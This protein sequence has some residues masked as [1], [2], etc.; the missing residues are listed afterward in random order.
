MDKSDYWKERSERRI[1]NAEKTA[2][3]MLRDI[4]KLYVETNDRITKEIEAFYGR[5][6]TE[7]GLSIADVK[8]LLTDEELNKFRREALKYYED[9]SKH[10]YDPAYREQLKNKI[11]ISTTKEGRKLYSLRRNVSR[12]DY[13]QVQMR[14]AIENMYMQQNEKFT[15]NLSKTYEDTYMRSV[16]DTQ[17]SSGLFVPFNSL[18]KPLVEKAVQQKWLGE[19]YSDR[20]WADKDKLINTLEQTFTQ[21]I[22]L[23]KNPRAMASDIKKLTGVKYS[24]CERLARTEFNHIANQATE[25]SYKANGVEKYKFVATLDTRT[26]AICQELSG[27]VFLLSEAEEGVNYPPM[28]CYDDKTEVLTKQGWKL[29]KNCKDDDLYFTMNPETMFPEWQKA[30]KK[31]E[32]LY[33]GNLIELKNR[34]FDLRVTPNHKMILKYAKGN[35]SGKLRFV[36]ADKLPKWSNAIP[37]GINWVGENLKTA[38]LGNYDIPIE[39]YLKF[40]AWWLSD[41]SC[42]KHKNKNAYSGVIGQETYNNLMYETLKDL[43]F[44]IGHSEKCIRFSDYSVCNELSKFGKCNNKYIPEIIK[45]LSADLIEIFLKAYSIADGHERI[46]KSFKGGNFGTEITFF[47]TSNQLASDLGELILKVGGRP[48]FKLQKNKGKAV[49]HHNGL[50]I[51]NFDCW[52]ITWGKRQWSYVETLERNLI[53]YNDYVYCVELQ[54]YHTLYV[55]RNGKCTWSGNSNCRSTTIP[56]YDDVDYSKMEQLATDPKTGKTYYIP[57]D[58]SYTDWKN[59]LTEEQGKYYAANKKM[60][61]QYKQDVKQANEYRKLVTKAKKAGHADLFEGYN[62]DVKSFQRLK[63]LQPE[64]YEIIKNNAKIARGL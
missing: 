24:N 31:I 17:Q 4:K 20:I 18:N 12:L 26:S 52:H 21:D 55:R 29:F 53:S 37:R 56:Y 10:V 19:N 51:G 63:Y 41:G 61:A 49:Q 60:N 33:N 3:E 36:E 13:I 14:Y 38:R 22:A 30:I 35:G 25:D 58:M 34:S 62:F 9:L 8:K 1:L 45:S 64:K 16:F 57:A 59:S 39:L 43:P 27:Q 2:D 6:A 42:T 23:G 15:Q 44:H 28:H 54:K 40:M 5:Y 32:Y 46:N 50:Y 11:Y 7:T 48:S 47:T